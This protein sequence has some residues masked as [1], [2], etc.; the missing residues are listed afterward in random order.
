MNAYGTSLG[1]IPA[2][3]EGFGVMIP[4]TLRVSWDNP[5]DLEELLDRYDGRVA[6]YIGEPVIG[7][8]GVIEAPDGY[9]PEIRRICTRARHP[10]HPGRGDLRLRPAR[11]ELRLHALRRRARP[12]HLREGRHVRLPAA[13]RRHRRPAREGPLLG[14]GRAA[15]RHGF[16]YS[17]H[18]ACCAAGLANLDI[19]EREELVARVA[20][21]EPVLA[22][23]VAPLRELDLVAEVRTRRP[24][25][26]H[27]VQAGGARRDARASPTRCRCAR[28][29][30][31][32]SPAR[33]AAS[34]CSS[35]RRS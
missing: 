22:D 32:S 8:G 14:R 11:R 15:F 13:R 16:T 19:L 24:P 33:C 17:G 35:R 29:R 7:A 28:A 27:R 26:R 12:D 1:G 5:E 23:A 10:V 34:A 20:E 6:A 2:N 21:L 25:R 9:W 18:A 31:A 30:T 3:L 4:E